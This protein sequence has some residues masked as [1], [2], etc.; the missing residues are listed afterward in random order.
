MLS[1]HLDTT[2]EYYHDIYQKFGACGSVLTVV[3]FNQGSKQDIEALIDYIYATLSLDLNYILS[4][5][6]NKCPGPSLDRV[7]TGTRLI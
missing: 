4:F 1:Q 3:P 6:A 2:V 5:A 7:W